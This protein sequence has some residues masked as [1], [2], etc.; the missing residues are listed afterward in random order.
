[1]PLRVVPVF[2][3][4][5]FFRAYSTVWSRARI[6]NYVRLAFAVATGVLACDAIIILMGYPH[7]HMVAF[8]ALYA[9]NAFLALVTLRFARPIVRDLF[10]ALDSARL[11]D[12]PATSRILVYGAGLRYS[13]FRR[14]LVR[15][16]TRNSRIIVGLIDDDLL[17]HGHYIGGIRVFGGLSS[18]KSAVRSLRADTVVIACQLT[19]DRLRLACKV[20][21][22]AGVRVTLWSCEEKEL[23]P[24]QDS[25]GKKC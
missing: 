15:G 7:V 8:T 17:I 22:D 1:M 12:D 21:A 24:C 6:S 14:E 4:L 20:F 2:F 13:A 5:V 3:A 16:A 25:T 19:P 18:A 23:E 9:Q 11:S 10:Y